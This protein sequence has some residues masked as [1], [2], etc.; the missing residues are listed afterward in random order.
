M[1]ALSEYQYPDGGF[2]RL[3]PEYEYD[4]STLHDTEHA[5]RY[6]FH[7]KKS[8]LQTTLLSKK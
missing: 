4:G 1:D 3:V 5:M 7:L 6:I 8:R 2:G